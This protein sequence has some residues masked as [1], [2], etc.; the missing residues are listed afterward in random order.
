MSF[1]PFNQS[2]GI[3]NPASGKH[4]G[5]VV[6]NEDPLKMGRVK[7]I[8]YGVVEEN[9]VDVLPWVYRKISFL[10]SGTEEISLIPEVGSLIVVEFL[11][12][13]VY[14]PV[15][16][17]QFQLPLKSSVGENYPNRIGFSLSDGTEV[18]Y[19]K[20]EKVL[21]VK[22]SSGHLLRMDPEEVLLESKKKLTLKSSTME[23]VSEGEMLLI[24][25]PITSNP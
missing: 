13:N 20:S 6:S 3:P 21:N 5:K 17:G 2:N 18:Y 25:N 19:D 4:I 1:Y 11:F 10:G 24:G 14:F 22:H 23:I 12:D 8:I 9:N 16:D 7:C 15:Y